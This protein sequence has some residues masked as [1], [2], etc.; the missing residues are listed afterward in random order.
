L[1]V[2][3]RQ[4]VRE[5]AQLMEKWI[6]IRRYSTSLFHIVKFPDNMR[7]LTDWGVLSKVESLTRNSVFLLSCTKKRCGFPVINGKSTIGQVCS[8]P[9]LVSRSNTYAPVAQ[10]DRVL[11]YEPRGQEFESLPAHHI[12]FVNQSLNAHPLGDF[13]FQHSHCRT[14]AGFK[15]QTQLLALPQT[16]HLFQAPNSAM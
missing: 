16:T 13:S 5:K 8:R 10:L 6:S 3:H 9:N 11:G 15:R 1:L 7:A 14:F 12:Q 2:I 4:A